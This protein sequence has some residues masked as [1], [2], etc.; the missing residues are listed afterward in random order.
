MKHNDFYKAETHNLCRKISDLQFAGKTDKEIARQLHLTPPAIN[1]IIW[2][3]RE[4]QEIKSDHE[5]SLTDLRPQ[6]AYKLWLEGKSFAEIG[7]KLKISRTR[8]QQIV[9]KY[10]WSLHLR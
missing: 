10:A 3:L 9:H 8:T 7:Q 4:S 2:L 1:F 6:T 5:R